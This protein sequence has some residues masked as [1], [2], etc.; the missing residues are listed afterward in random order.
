MTDER[1]MIAELIASL[2]AC[3]HGMQHAEQHYLSPSA[4]AEMW[5]YINGYENSPVAHDVLGR[6]QEMLRGD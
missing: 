3:F 5:S 1:E 4:A 2:D 6:A